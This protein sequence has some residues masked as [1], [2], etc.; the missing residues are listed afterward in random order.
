MRRQS[1]SAREDAEFR[2]SLRVEMAAMRGNGCEA[3]LLTPVGVWPPR[4]F[5]DLH[6]VLSRARGGDVRDWGN[7]LLVC[8]S[9]HNWI[10][11]H[12]ADAER[13]GLS[14]SMTANERARRLHPWSVPNDSKDAVELDH[15]D[16]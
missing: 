4:P 6:E 10:T 11:T 7:I 8:R 5:D 3:C 9:C 1:D 2:R 14:R 15:G 12:P 16:D 13:L